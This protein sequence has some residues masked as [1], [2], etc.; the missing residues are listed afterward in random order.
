M[1]RARQR[2]E[3]Y[4]TRPGPAG[5]ASFPAGLPNPRRAGDAVAG[6]PASP[7]TR[8]GSERAPTMRPRT[9]P[10]PPALLL[11]LVLALLAAAPAAGKVSAG[12]RDAGPARCAPNPRFAGTRRP[13]PRGAVLEPLSGGCGPHA[14]PRASSWGRE[15]VGMPGE[16]VECAGL[17]EEA[18]R[19][20]VLFPKNQ[21]WA[22]GASR[23]Q[24]RER[25][26]K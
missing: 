6:E 23:D 14:G 21:W 22:R 1:G 12:R 10:R 13:H 8:R 5:E 2:A 18:R 20:L 16:Q 26:K 4:K 9:A 19:K 15:Q 3:P 11:P 25:E 24:E 17:E 7:W